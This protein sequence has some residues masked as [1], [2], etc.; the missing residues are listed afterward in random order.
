M[1]KDVTKNVDGLLSTLSAASKDRP[2]QVESFRDEPPTRENSRDE[3]STASRATSYD[4][5]TV[6]EVD[7]TSSRESY[8][9]RLRGKREEVFSFHSIF[10]GLYS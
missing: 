7:E 1:S 6:E 4:E 3:S 5:D 2:D 8:E 9:R 10:A